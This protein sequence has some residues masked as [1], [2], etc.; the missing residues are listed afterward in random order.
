M[1]VAIIGTGYVGTVAGAC[2]AEKGHQVVCVEKDKQKV[3]MLEMGNPVIYEPGLEPLVRGNLERKRLRFTDSVEQAVVECEIIFM[4]VGTPSLPDGRPDLSYLESAVRAVGHFMR[5][6]KIIVNKS[7]VPVG[8]HRQVSEWLREET[9][10]PFEVV[11]NPEFLRE[12]SA[13]E[14]FLCPERVVIGTTCK[15]TFAKMRELYQPFC[16]NEQP[17]L[18]MDPVSA[19]L[20]KYACNAFLATRISYMND[21]SRLCERV[22]GDI[23][24]IRKGM[25]L[26]SRIGPQFLN[27][28]IGYGGSCFPKDI[29]ALISLAEDHGTTLRIVSAVEEVNERQKRV[30]L[31]R[32]L[33]HL[34]ARAASK[35]VAI[36]GL[37]YKPDTDDIR[38]APALVLAEELLQRGV[39]VVAYDPVAM[40]SVR[41]RF[42]ERIQLCPNAYAALENANALI[43]ATEWGEFRRLDFARMKLL[44]AEPAI[45]DGRNLLSPE[46]VEEAGFTYSSIGRAMSLNTGHQAQIKPEAEEFKTSASNLMLR[47]VT[48]SEFNGRAY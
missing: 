41:R 35:R 30:L 43:I 2:F 23:R 40:P 21:L 17:I 42:E 12:G 26:D 31:P 29:R 25:G 32:I 4:T 45:F 19:E 34:G 11:S 27:A 46:E 38:E 1:K 6:K 28:G 24:E 39:E 18:H 36:W 3:Q 8:T 16:T 44:M 48:Q 15:E 10:V 13:V 37:A 14:D 7:T 5:E 47:K 9:R 33:K 20:T 22:G